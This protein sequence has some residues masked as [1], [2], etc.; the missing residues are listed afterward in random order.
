MWSV[1]TADVSKIS[2]RCRLV[3]V[4]VYFCGLNIFVTI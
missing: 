4:Y 2:T 1:S 3:F